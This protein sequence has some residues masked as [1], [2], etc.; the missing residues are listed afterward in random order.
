MTSARDVMCLYADRD[1][2]FQ[3]SVSVDLC[4]IDIGH[5]RLL[6]SRMDPASPRY[7]G[8]YSAMH[9]KNSD[10]ADVQGI[11]YLRKERGYGCQ[12]C[13]AMD[14]PEINEYSTR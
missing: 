13:I 10:D 2:H 8:S 12:V 9:A 1:P 3:S 5:N 14:G 4:S 7:G 11:C 6:S